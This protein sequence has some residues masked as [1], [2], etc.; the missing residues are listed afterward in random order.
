LDSCKSFSD[1]QRLRIKKLQRLSVTRVEFGDYEQPVII[2]AK[3]ENGQEG[4]IY[5]FQK[6]TFYDEKFHGLSK[7]SNPDYY[8]EYF[9]FEDPRKVHPTWGNAIWKL[10]E[11]GEVAIG[12]TE[13]MVKLACVDSMVNG[14]LQGE[15]FV[16]SPSGEEVSPI[17][18]CSGRKFIVEKGKVTK[19]VDA[20]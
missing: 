16:I 12:M 6:R 19:Y 7:Y 13:D 15:G 17:Y 10:I 4:Q 14:E 8:L 2:F 1:D 20:R 11:E 18:K 3:I 9:L 5:P